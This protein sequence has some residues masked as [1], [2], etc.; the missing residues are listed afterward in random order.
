LERCR[1]VSLAGWDGFLGRGGTEV[2]SRKKRRTMRRKSR[3]RKVRRSYLGVNTT[4]AAA[5]EGRG[6][7]ECKK[8]RS[9]KTR[10][11]Q[12][13]AHGKYGRRRLEFRGR[14]GERASILDHRSVKGEGPLAPY[15]SE[16]ASGKLYQDATKYQERGTKWGGWGGE[17]VWEG[18]G[19]VLGGGGVGAGGGTEGGEAKREGWGGG[20]RG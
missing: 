3:L 15:S 8:V 16:K 6:F 4:R 19:G 12:G 18:G 17:R 13:T 10:N 11:P 1:P 7:T 14:G 20:A 2:P 5:R 9:E